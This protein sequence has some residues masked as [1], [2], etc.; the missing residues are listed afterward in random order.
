[1]TSGTGPFWSGNREQVFSPR[2]AGDYPM[3]RHSRSRAEG[4]VSMAVRPERN[5]K[6][7][8]ARNLKGCFLSNRCFNCTNVFVFPIEIPERCSGEA[9]QL[10]GWTRRP[11][12]R[13]HRQQESHRPHQRR[14]HCWLSAEASCDVLHEGKSSHFICR[15]DSYTEKF[16]LNQS[17]LSTPKWH[18]CIISMEEPPGSS[19]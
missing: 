14:G 17:L 9:Q 4:N 16:I 11:S 12:Q 2:M 8:G 15:V 19:S 7:F 3:K 18:S 1:M 10:P 6:T 5:M 13:E